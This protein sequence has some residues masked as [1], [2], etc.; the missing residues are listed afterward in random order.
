MVVADFAHQ[1]GPERLPREIFS[2][3]PAAGHSGTAL[4]LLLRGPLG[5]ARPGMI[6]ERA[7]AV[8]RE[9]LDQLFAPLLGERSGHADVL[10][11]ALFIIEAEEQRA[12]ALAGAVLVPAEP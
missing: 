5:P 8:R 1:L 2:A 10:E 3:V 7:L 9:L 11:L 6:L 4:R 12:D